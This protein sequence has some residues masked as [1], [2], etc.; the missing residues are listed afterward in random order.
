MSLQSPDHRRERA[1]NEL[2]GS[3]AARRCRRHFLRQFPAGFRDPTYLAWERDYKWAAHRRWQLE[4]NQAMFE[5]L[6]AQEQYRA[7]ASSAIAIEARTNLLFSFE[8]MALRD[9]VKPAGGARAFALGLHAFLHGTAPP[10]ARFEAWVET[11]AALP[12]RQT[13]VLTWPA[14]TV[15][16]MLAR[17]KTHLFLK[18][19]VTR[20]AAARYGF[21]FEY[22]S[23]PDWATYSSL[24]AFA[25]DIRKTMAD[26]PARDMIDLQGFI[27]VC[28]SD[29]YPW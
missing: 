8:K 3:V 23:R 2:A 21:P 10:R 29:E 1:P 18:P 9:A 19:Q 11:M 7:V 13:R 28:G 15:F 22:R 6:L 16:G 4:L 25:A 17:P 5:A 14:L 24:H 20:T 26:F 12:R 27:W